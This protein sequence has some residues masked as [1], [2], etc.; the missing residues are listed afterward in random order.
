MQSQRN[1]ELLRTAVFTS[2][3]ISQMTDRTALFTESLRLTSLT[4][5]KISLLSNKSLLNSKAG[6]HVRPKTWS[7]FITD[8]DEKSRWI[9]C[10]LQF[11]V[12]VLNARE[13]NHCFKTCTGSRTPDISRLWEKYRCHKHE[14]LFLCL[15]RLGFSN[16]RKNTPTVFLP[17][18]RLT[19][20]KLQCFNYLTSG[21][22]EPM[23]L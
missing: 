6:T 21:S 9:P 12:L 17:A 7:C 8:S 22:A 11:L 2:I 3:L 13:V 4:A 19:E 18:S 23:Y 15:Y 10:M 14:K 5:F 20:Q 1:P 16:S